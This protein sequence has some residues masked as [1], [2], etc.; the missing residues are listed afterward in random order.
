MTTR[1]LKS[2]TEIEI[3]PILPED[4]E[5]LA[6][7]YENLSD[8]T[9]QSFYRCSIPKKQLARKEKIVQECNQNSE[10]YF[11]TVALCNDKII[12][13]NMIIQIDRF[14]GEYEIGNLVS[15]EFQNMG[16]GS[17][18]MKEMFRRVKKNHA[19]LKL[20]AHTTFNNYR[21]RFHLLKFGFSLD[22]IIDEEFF[23]VCTV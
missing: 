4:T 20:I 9:I 3:R 18:L 6:E 5:R 7:F 23:W 2:G 11:R 13:I 15:D 14:S 17:V 8:K 19:C 22:N 1:V 12:A 21:A 16:V 10:E